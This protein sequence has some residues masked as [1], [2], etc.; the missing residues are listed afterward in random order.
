MEDGIIRIE[1][2][3]ATAEHRVPKPRPRRRQAPWRTRR[4]L[5]VKGPLPVAWFC[6]AC[7]LGKQAARVGLAL[8]FQRGIGA[9][10]DVVRINNQLRER[11]K[12]TGDCAHR[13]LRALVAA[14]LVRVVRGGRGRCPVVQIVTDDE[15]AQ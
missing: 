3:R 5:F 4:P 10:R 1:S 13:G 7:D 12:I 2:F 8:W 15:A 6:R 11:F 14:G 9:D